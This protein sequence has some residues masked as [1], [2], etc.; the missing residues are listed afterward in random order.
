VFS[1]LR[2]C[3][4]ERDTLPRASHPHPQ[5]VPMTLETVR[6]ICRALPAVTE[7]IKWGHDLCFSVAGR[8]FAVVNIERPHSIAFKCTP[9]M[10]GELVERPGIIPAPYMARNMWVQEQELGEALD[11]REIESLVKTS[12]ELVVA[13]L[14]KS[15]RP[16]AAAPS[17]PKRRP[18]RR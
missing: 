17:P 2:G 7:D 13:K 1:C 4:R 16:A 15:K 11:R 5:D 12:Y 18:K 9:E 10:F 3:I 14:P 8:M 6:S